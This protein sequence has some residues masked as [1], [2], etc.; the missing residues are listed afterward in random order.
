MYG[1]ALA[2]DFHVRTPSKT[3]VYDLTPTQRDYGSM[4]ILYCLY[5]ISHILYEPV[6][7]P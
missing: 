2:D 3:P 1:D 5:K 7:Q 4:R 6:V